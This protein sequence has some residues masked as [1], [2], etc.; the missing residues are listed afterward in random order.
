MIPVTMRMAPTQR[1]LPMVGQY[2]F[3]CHALPF[4]GVMPDVRSDSVNAMAARPI[5]MS[6]APSTLPMGIRPHLGFTFVS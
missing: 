5:S 2:E 3:S 6:K 4:T 1:P